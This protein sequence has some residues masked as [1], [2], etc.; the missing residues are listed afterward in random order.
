M[1]KL[2][3]LNRKEKKEI[4]SL[5]EKQW[6]FRNELGYVF[7]MSDAGKIYL[8]GKDVFE[9]NLA[10]LKVDSIGLYFGELK[11]GILRLSIEGAQIIGPH[12]K[13][14]LVELTQKEMRQWLH[15]IDLDKATKEKGFTIIR[16]VDNF[17]GTGKCT[18]SKIL[19]F[20][21]KARRVTSSD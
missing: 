15:G 5:L 13:R 2:R 20:V 11:D 6:G 9:I 17:L 7:L 8:S 3:I 4:L 19:N 1:Q 16:Y 10:E 12:A 18:G 21:P 14:S